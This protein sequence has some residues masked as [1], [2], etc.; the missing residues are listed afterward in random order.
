[1]SYPVALRDELYALFL[2]AHRRPDAAAAF[3]EGVE[4]LKGPGRARYLRDRAPRFLKVLQAW[5]PGAPGD[6]GAE[7]DLAL[8][9]F[10]NGLYF[11]THEYLE[12]AWRRSTGER[13]LQLQGL[14]QLAAALHKLEL[15]PRAR[16][17]ARYLVERGFDKLKGL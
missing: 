14:I 11:D 13:K 17:G 2:R 1:M 12:T 4:N 15:D 8:L 5:K 7:L 16:A 10:Q 6:L 3:R 9:L